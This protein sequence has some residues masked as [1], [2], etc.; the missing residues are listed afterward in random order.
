[1]LSYREELRDLHHRRVKYILLGGGLLMLLFSVLDYF[2]VPE[3]FKEFLAYRLGA[4]LCVVALFFYNRRDAEKEFALLTGFA[5]YLAVVASIIL[6][7]YRMEG[8]ESPYY[9]G[10]I[11]AV[12]LYVTL[13]PL[14]PLQTLLSGLVVVAGYVVI[15]LLHEQVGQPHLILLFNHLFFIVCFVLIVST[16]SWADTVARREEYQ[17]RSEE[18]RDTEELS[19]RIQL[20]ENEVEV[21]SREQEILERR[22]QQLFDQIADGV[23][24]VTPEGRIVQ[25]N[26]AFNHLFGQGQDTEDM[27]F[28]DLSPE[29]EHVS[30]QRIFDE[31]I[32]SGVQVS[33]GLFSLLSGEGG[34]TEVE[35]KGSVLKRKGKAVGILLIIRDLRV[36]REM[37]LK[38]VQTL[39]V[40]KRTETSAILV[41]AKLSE[42]KDLTPLNHLERVR[43]YCKLLAVQLS[44]SKNLRE[45]MT[46]TYI[47]DIY[48]ASILHDIGK[49]AIPDEYM[50]GDAP[51][52]EYEKDYLRRHTLIGGD[53]I[54]GM[55]EE[56]E[57]NGFL[58]IAKHIAYFHHERWDG[59][60]YPYGL[61]GREIPL[62]AR[63]M[64]LVDFYEELTAAE[65][66]GS[67]EEHHRNAVEVI[68]SSSG[69]RLDPMVVDSF[70][71]ITEQFAEVIR[72]LPAK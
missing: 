53:V 19:D 30:L 66:N 25:A 37:E 58:T 49:V 21:R 62:A 23:V 64:A 46:S 45:V 72:D 40:Q 71:E 34:R 12:T 8:V 6:S 52:E 15:A 42:F 70:L 33:A 67:A 65:T 56:S 7:I 36:R 47:E 17:L 31:V 32:V 55:E 29:D 24:V 60:G 28:F 50:A 61:G 22:Y 48:H 10:L 14:T 57:G 44:A 11:V 51:M 27:S 3:S 26:A 2:V 41:L 9:V 18:Q 69:S 35:M 63:I 59:K 38:L 16:Q 68:A 1:M 13:A 20:L 5:G 54:R 43:E 39:K 4:G